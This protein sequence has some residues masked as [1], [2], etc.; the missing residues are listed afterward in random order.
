MDLSSGNERNPQPATSTASSS[1]SQGDPYEYGAGPATTSTIPAPGIG[2]DQRQVAVTRVIDGDTFEIAEGDKVRVLGIDAC[3]AGTPGGLA[4][5]DR[6]RFSLTLAGNGPITV[7]R[8]PGADRDQYGRM[9]RYVQLGGADFGS[10]MVTYDD[11]GVY[12]GNNDAA[13]DYV[14]RLRQSESPRNCGTQ[15]APTATPAP[16]T[17]VEDDDYKSPVYVEDEVDTPKRRTGNSGH[18]C[19]PG[20]RDGDSDGYCGEGR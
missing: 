2:V 6:A 12:E 13:P 18:P 17:Y 20:E 7:T 16:P 14:D 3:E 5:T 8:E 15:P 19:L 9:L 4:A 10:W 11:V 1:Y